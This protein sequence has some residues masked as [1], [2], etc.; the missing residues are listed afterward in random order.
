M[1]LRRRWNLPKKF[2]GDGFQDLAY[3]IWNHPESGI[4]ATPVLF[5]AG[6]A[7]VADVFIKPSVSRKELALD[8]TLNNPTGQPIEGELICEAIDA[9][10]KVVKTFAPR[11]IPLRPGKTTTV[12]L[13]EPW[14]SPS[15]WWPDEPRLY[16]LRTTLK[17][18]GRTLDVTQTPFGFREWTIAGKDFRL[19]GI[20][21]HGW[22]DTHNHAN[23][24]RVARLLPPDQPDVHAVLGH[25]LDGPDAGRRA[26]LLRQ[27][28]R[29]RP[30]LGHAR[31]RGYRLHGHRERSRAQ[32]AVRLRNQDGTDG[33]LA[34]SDDRTG[35]R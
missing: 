33:K 14:A 6:P 30:P 9:A 13:A 25:A 16:R 2:F 31:R 17:S 3:P 8:V 10:G 19:N 7:Y 26:R 15:L 28:R 34:R 11:T 23:C 5:L 4:L 18:D 32:E 12:A 24:A 1:K 27:E 20:P 22:A 29:A 21:W 35:Q